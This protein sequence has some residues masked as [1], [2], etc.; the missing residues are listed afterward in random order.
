MSLLVRVACA[1]CNTESEALG[2]D[3]RVD[4]GLVVRSAQRRGWKITRQ[5]KA[6]AAG[7]KWHALCPACAAVSPNKGSK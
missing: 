4:G 2:F 5:K 6:Y 7:L 3:G 1:K